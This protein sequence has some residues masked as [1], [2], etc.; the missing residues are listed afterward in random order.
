MNG[1][2]LFLLGRA[3]MRIGEAALPTV[4]ADAVAPTKGARAVLIVA[5]DIAQHPGSS[6]SEI[7]LRSG[8]PQSQVS[9]AVARLAE[10]GSVVTSIDPSDR[11]RKLVE[12]APGI[13]GR[14]AEV[15]ASSIT[16]ELAA[17]LDTA[18]SRRIQRVTALLEEL[19]RE[20]LPE[21]DI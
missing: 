4:P 18:D 16:T 10:A 6:V 5:S 11:R 20:L 15:R 2:D 17:A 19:G 21:R 13:S 12:R 1:I 9:T 3:L 14:V 7:A 8:F